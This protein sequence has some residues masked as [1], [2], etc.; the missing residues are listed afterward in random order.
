MQQMLGPMNQ[1]T[2]RKCT[3]G[4]RPAYDRHAC[5]A[6]FGVFNGKAA[7]TRQQCAAPATH[8]LWETCTRIYGYDVTGPDPLPSLEECHY[9]VTH[10]Q[11]VRCVELYSRSQV[12]QDPALPSNYVSPQACWSW[13]NGGVSL[14]PAEEQYCRDNP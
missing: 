1:L 6:M 4:S 10:A 7:P 13:Q 9:P 14:T 8:D 2:L 11:W 5:M 12:G 3:N